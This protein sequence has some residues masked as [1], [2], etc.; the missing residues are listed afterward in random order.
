ML[1]SFRMTHSLGY[2]SVKAAVNYCGRTAGLTDDQILSG[3]KKPPVS[4][5]L[6]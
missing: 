1:N 6:M 5:D 2:N 4:F 3:H